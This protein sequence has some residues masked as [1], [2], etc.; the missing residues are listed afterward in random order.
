MNFRPG[1]TWCASAALCVSVLL[2]TVALVAFGPSE[3]GLDAA[4]MLTGRWAFLLF[5]PA[6][7]GSGLVALFG[8][9]F[10]FLKQHARSFGLALAA[11]MLVHV[12]L[13]G[14]L[15]A[16]GAAPAR[17]VFL[18]FGPPL[19]CIYILALFSLNALQRSLG[20]Q[21]FWLLRTVAMNYIAFAFATDLLSNPFGVG[22]KHI[23]LYAP[24]ALLSVLGFAAYASA[25]L[26]SIRKAFVAT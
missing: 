26:L 10:Y 8:D 12:G 9:K 5:L 2:S 14:W 3:R 13:I 15:C 20:R 1:I 25:Q 16:I 7:A 11:A 19:I 18:F 21:L 4:L 24:F 6:Y 22:F 23:V 17:G